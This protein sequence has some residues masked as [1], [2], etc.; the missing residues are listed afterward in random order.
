VPDPCDPDAHEEFKKTMNR[1]DRLEA[2]RISVD[3]FMF[4]QT[5]E[6]DGENFH[7]EAGY[8]RLKR[9]TIVEGEDEDFT[10]DKKRKSDV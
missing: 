4:A 3:L 5:E 10:L 7:V 8:L 9:Q 6:E 1:E 2:D